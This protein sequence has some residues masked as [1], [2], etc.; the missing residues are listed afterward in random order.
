MLLINLIVIYFQMKYGVPLHIFLK[1]RPDVQA[2]LT[3]YGPYERFVNL[4]HLHDPYKLKSIEKE[5][6][7]GNPKQV[8]AKC[9]KLINSQIKNFNQYLKAMKV[10]CSQ[11]NQQKSIVHQP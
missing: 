6:C 4:T 5:R 2:T 7:K 10:R 9:Y 8:E 3:Q 1:N 11:T